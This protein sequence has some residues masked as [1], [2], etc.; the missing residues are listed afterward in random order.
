MTGSSNHNH[1]GDVVSVGETMIYFQTEDF[2][3]LRYAQRFEKF[4]GGTESNTLDYPF[5]HIAMAFV[6]VCPVH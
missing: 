4:I 3:L 2:G 6:S 5:E 1:P